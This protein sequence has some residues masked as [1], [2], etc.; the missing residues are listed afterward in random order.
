MNFFDNLVLPQS[1]EHIIL[2]HYL[3]IM[4]QFLFLPFFSLLIAGTVLS[5]YHK[6]KARKTGDARYLRF[7]S[8]IIEIAAMN[9]SMGIIL[10]IVPVAALIMIYAQLLHT[11]EVGTVTYLLISLVFLTC[12]VIAIY[13]Y[14]YA[15]KY[16]NLFAKLS[17]SGVRGEASDKLKEADSNVKKLNSQAGK[18]GVLLLLAGTYFL[19][20]ALYIAGHPDYWNENSNWVAIISSTGIYLKWLQLLSFAFT[21]TAAVMLFVYFFWEGG[22]LKNDAEYGDFVKG[23]L[24]R[25]LFISGILQPLFITGVFVSYPASALSNLVF[26]FVIIMF[27]AFFA[28][29]HLLYDMYKN[30]HLKHTVSLMALLF[31]SLYSGAIAEQFS[32]KNSTVK[33]SVLMNV[34]FEE[35]VK[36][37]EKLTASAAGLT[38]EEIFT[39]KCSACHKY[40]QK[41]VGP[42]YNDVLPKY[43]GKMADLVEFVKNPVK[44]DPAYPPMPNQGLKPQEAK[45]IAKYIMENYKK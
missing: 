7:A 3:A 42:A 41:V 44:V 25:I 9:K 39:Q 37:L 40:D 35:S 12:A 29:F 2:L 30:G 32:V 34:V 23:K 1:T 5:I 8:E 15:F 43:E 45:A 16:S 19:T 21:I 10:G 13:S 6:N 31:V 26:L 28:A 24:F 33:N 38:G 18:W 20:A 14:R 4:L 17:E 36:N 22:R 11:M 27:F